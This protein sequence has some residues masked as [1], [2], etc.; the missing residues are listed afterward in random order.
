VELGGELEDGLDVVCVRRCEALK[1]HEE[2]RAVIPDVVD[3][4]SGAVWVDVPYD[5]F[6]VI[7]PPGEDVVLGLRRALRWL[8]NLGIIR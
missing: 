2:R 4:A 5:L 8:G 7:R 6:D 3:D 1:T